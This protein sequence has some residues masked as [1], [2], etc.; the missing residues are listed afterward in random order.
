MGNRRA[1]FPRV[2]TQMNTVRY[3]KAR[4]KPV[5]KE[6]A[7]QVATGE[8]KKG[9][10]GAEKEVMRKE[11]Q[12]QQTGWSDREIDG[13]Q[14]AADLAAAS[15]TLNREG[16]DVVSVTAITSGRYDSRD[17]HCGGQY[18]GGSGGYGYGY[19]YTEGLVVTA[20]KRQ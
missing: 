6:V 13:E 5:G 1:E 3:I 4:F 10:F 12:W 7:V 2:N 18:G 11:K 20:V 19:S 17:M 15:E 8:K 16:Y 9:L 14:L